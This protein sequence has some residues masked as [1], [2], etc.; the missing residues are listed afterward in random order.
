[1]PTGTATVT[2]KTGPAIQNT[3]LALSGVTLVTYDVARN[4]LFVTITGG[5][6]KEFELQGVTTATIT[7]ASGNFAFAVS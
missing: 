5:V 3:N 4:M 6:V 7:I 2:A 1:M